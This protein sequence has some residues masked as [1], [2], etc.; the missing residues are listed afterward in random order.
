[1]SNLLGK[2][3]RS[4][5]SFFDGLIND[6]E[7]ASGKNYIDV[8]LIGQILTNL[9]QKIREL[10]LEPGDV[11]PEEFYQATMA[12]FVLTNQAFGANFTDTQTD[13]IARIN[14]LINF[15]LPTL[16]NDFIKQLL[17]ANPPVNLLKHFNYQHIDQLVDLS[18]LEILL[19]AQSSESQAWLN[20]SH[21]YLILNLKPDNLEQKPLQIKIIDPKLDKFLTPTNE[22]SHLILS[23]LILL[24]SS[25]VS[26]DDALTYFLQILNDIKQ[27]VDLSNQ[28]MLMTSLNWQQNWQKWVANKTPFVWTMASNP[29]PWRGI[30]RAFASPISPL[31]QLSQAEVN[32]IYFEPYLILKHFSELEFW[33]DSQNLAFHFNNEVISLNLF[34]VAHNYQFLNQNYGTNDFFEQALWENLINNYLKNQNLAEQVYKQWQNFN[35]V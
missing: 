2:L 5:G 9:N 3:L 33:Q 1:M 18:P 12:K 22:G 13:I 10:G 25:L 19:L 11:F 30:I 7:N 20:R 35:R 34:D 24:K 31:H 32:L 4:E 27:K 23:N 15:Q 8:D 26:Q 29:V 28:F 17:S 14:N 21:E 16:S 6:L